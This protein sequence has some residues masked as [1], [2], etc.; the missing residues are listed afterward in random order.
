MDPIKLDGTNLKTT[1]R[2]SSSESSN[3]TAV[4]S[5]FRNSFSQA[6][7]RNYYDRNSSFAALGVR[8]S[9]ENLSRTLASFKW[10]D[11]GFSIQ[12]ERLTVP[13]PGFDGKLKATLSPK[14]SPIKYDRI[15]SRGF[16]PEQTSLL[17]SREYKFQ[18]SYGSDSQTF[19]INVT[20]GIKNSEVLN[21]VASAVNT[22]SMPVQADIVTQTAPGLNHEDLLGTGSALVFSVNSAYGNDKLGFRD[23]SGQL[24]SS[25]KLRGTEDAIGPAETG[26]YS[27]KSVS[28][29]SVSSFLSK[30]FEK[31]ASTTLNSGEHN[32]DY[33]FGP[34]SGTVTFTVSEGDTWGDVFNNIINSI[35]NVSDRISADVV[36]TKAPSSVYTGD[37]FLMTDTQAVKI[38]SVAPKLGERLQL[39]P[40]SSL[41]ALGLGVTSQPGSDAELI[42][43]G[44]SQV[45]APG[46]FS[47]DKGRLQVE[48]E[49]V[50]GQPLPLRVV[51]AVEEIESK[52]SAIA[53]SYNSF[54]KS[55]LPVEDLFK[56][57]FGDAWRNPVDKNSVD[58][59]WMGL[60]EAGKDKML[61]FE[62]DSFY[63]A[64]ASEPDKVEQLL[65]DASEGLVSV[66]TAET[67]KVLENG[68]DSYLIP[69][70]SL[71]DRLLPEPSPRTE[72]ELEQSS[73]LLDLYENNEFDF[74]DYGFSALVDYK[75]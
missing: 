5:V 48:V 44:R 12:Q 23:L 65:T 30:S 55:F 29:G 4:D 50:T 34:D 51:E 68:V 47:L 64:M 52:F 72:N 63:K 24:I 59:K 2:G 13:D 43:N 37:D 25:L 66:W 15:V 7:L 46:L 28:K 26:R 35:E 53:D 10:P 19:K 14:D 17:D 58:L 1:D 45:R 57:G 71:P 74:D 49:D 18:M 69:Q 54:R 75:G 38:S 70:S 41:S 33:S 31:N 3:T 22:S 39:S 8:Q 73:E 62:A 67:E 9:L 56:S 40:D 20:D 16:T 60:R 11:T 32:I 6:Q 27:L 42:V 21:L 36:E 61:W